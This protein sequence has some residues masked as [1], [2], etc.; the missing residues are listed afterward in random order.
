[1]AKFSTAAAIAIVSAA[2]AGICEETGFRGYMQRPIEQ[3]HGAL[4]RLA[5]DEAFWVTLLHGLLDKGVIAPRHRES[6]HELA[7]SARPDGPL[8]QV[9]ARACPAGRMRLSQPYFV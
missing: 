6:L 3:R 4:V 8:G 2:S 7:A 1:M 9:V 5:P